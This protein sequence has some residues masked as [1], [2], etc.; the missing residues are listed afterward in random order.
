MP[1]RSAKHASPVMYPML[2]CGNS[3]PRPAHGHA[4]QQVIPSEE[5]KTWAAA[6]ET[7]HISLEEEAKAAATAVVP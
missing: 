6:M 4:T 1:W 5:A 7:A 2:R 3:G